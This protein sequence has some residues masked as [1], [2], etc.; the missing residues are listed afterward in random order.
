MAIVQFLPAF[1]M[2][3]AIGSYTW[4][5]HRIIESWGERSLIFCEFFHNDTM[6]KA[7]YYRKYDNMKNEDDTIIY[8]FSIGSKITDYILGLP[9][10][11]I[12]IYH[13]ITPP[14][15]FRMYS[16]ILYREVKKGRDELLSLKGKFDL[17]LADSEYNREELAEA[18]FENACLLPLT[19]NW[20]D[21]FAVRPC[22]IYKKMFD[23]G[24][25][26]ILFTGKISPQKRIEDL[27]KVFYHYKKT[28]NP[29]SRLI[30]M[31]DKEG[32]FSHYYLSI[33]SM[34]N[35]LGLDDVVF[36]GFTDARQWV[37]VYRSA[38]IFLCLSAHEGFCAPVM[39]AMTAGIP[40]VSVGDCALKYTM[41][42]GGVL[43]DERDH[44]KT[45]FLIDRICRDNEL[46]KSIVANQDR[47]YREYL[48]KDLSKILKGYLDR[49][50]AN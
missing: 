48:K 46:K 6:D 36:T 18:G 24:R 13:N 11:K 40:V 16:R 45:A 35:R 22:R 26:N 41:G 8:H 37:S 29:Q 7:L 19:I 14:E 47:W 50:D 39:E 49:L 34:I 43:L 44:L 17:Y 10:K 2:G 1:R 9:Q 4:H 3:D 12:M 32:L 33:L 30:L 27:I 25:V 5:I 15:Y 42:Y 28:L 20:E 38:D 31:G 23:D 21:L